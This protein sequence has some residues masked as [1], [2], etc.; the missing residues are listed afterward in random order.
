MSENAPLVWDSELKLFSPA[1][2]RQWTAAMA[3]TALIMTL[4]LGTV[5]AAQGEWDAI[6]TMAMISAGA[7]GGLW[8]LGL[9]VMLIVF[10]GRVAVSYRVD[11]EG[12]AMETR[13]RVARG[14]NR[15]AIVIG[16]LAG[17]PGL[18][19]AGMIGRS[20][21]HEA[22]R[23]AGAF[24]T[25]A[26]S[27]RRLI[28]IRNAWRSVL[29]VQCT[30]ANFEAVQARIRDEMARHETDKRLPR[31][32]PLPFYLIH[33]VLIFAASVPLFW[34]S[35]EYD[36]SLLLPL[37]ALAFAQATLWLIN[38]FGW[39]VCAL[40]L[41]I[42]GGVAIDLAATRTSSL[43][44]GETY[45]GFDVLGSDDLSGLAAALVGAAYLVWLSIRALRG[46]FLALLLRDA[47]ETDG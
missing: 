42:A 29:L 38:L 23:W 26:D 16:A 45:T 1:M 36:V 40:L 28:D 22:V 17:K 27:R 3:V 7:A 10:R 32:S 35:D 30:P 20:R 33:T 12:I 43:F 37:L 8:L 11:S 14:A 21:E 41:V 34:L 13:D 46:R 9:A 2:I 25:A 19:G 6:G 4:L 5:F 15:A 31:R 24:H 44:P 47:S 18:A 39:V